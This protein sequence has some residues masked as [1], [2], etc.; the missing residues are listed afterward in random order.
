PVQFSAS[1]TGSGIIPF[2]QW[3]E[4]G[5]DIPGATNA[6][7]TIAAASPSQNSF[8]YSVFVSNIFGSSITST[9]GTLTVVLDTNPPTVLS[10]S[11]LLSNSLNVVFSEQ[12]DG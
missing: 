1:W 8:T 5:S 10:V 2:I 4:N 7:Y 11:S 6:T 12:M 9:N 3:R